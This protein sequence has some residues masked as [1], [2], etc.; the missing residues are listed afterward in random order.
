[1]SILVLLLPLFILGR[2]LIVKDLTV[3]YFILKVVLLLVSQ[4]PS[5]TCRWIE[6]AILDL[7]V[8]CT[9]V[10]RSER[11][12]VFIIEAIQPSMTLRLLHLMPIAWHLTLHA[13]AVVHELVLGLHMLARLLVLVS[14]HLS[15]L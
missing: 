6:L 5:S 9:V 1:M 2:L 3:V 12:T 11:I 13:L 4:S 15:V 10:S 8:L 7:V 14:I